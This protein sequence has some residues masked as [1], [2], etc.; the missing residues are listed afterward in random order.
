MTKYNI[1]LIIHDDDV[2]NVFFMDETR[3][4]RR[5]VWLYPDGSIQYLNVD[6]N[7]HKIL[8]DGDTE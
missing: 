3:A 8:V 7:E 1:G 5:K 6:T 4:M 2:V